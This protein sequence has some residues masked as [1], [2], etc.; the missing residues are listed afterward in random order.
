MRKDCDPLD[1]LDVLIK[2]IPDDLYSA[3]K[4]ECETLEKNDL[5]KTGL[6]SNGV[7]THYAIQNE[8]TLR[9]LQLFVSETYA[10][11]RDIFPNN[12]FS[13]FS[14]G[15]YHQDPIEPISLTLGPPWY[16]LQKKGEYIPVHKHS[17]ILSYSGWINVP[18][19]FDE[20]ATYERDQATVGCFQFVYCHPV[21]GGT[22]NHTIRLDKSWE[23]KFMMFS[24]ALSHCVYPFY[25]SDGKRIS[26]SGNILL[27][28]SNLK[29]T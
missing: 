17:G 10:E 18:F 19:T 11:Y 12:D 5:F 6:T 8:E 1:F 21:F 14:Y 9:L 16:N 7:S 24:P 22:V 29:K 23:K 25:N 27:D 13:K 4:R 20:E 26:F 3:F 2:D 28:T 15:L